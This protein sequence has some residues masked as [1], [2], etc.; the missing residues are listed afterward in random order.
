MR[1]RLFSTRWTLLALALSFAVVSGCG[2]QEAE[3]ELK[4]ASDSVTTAL[5][6]WKRGDSAKSLLTSSPS[7]EFHDDDWQ[8]GARLTDFEI[9]QTYHDTDGAPRS[10]VK[11]T[12]ERDG[13][14]KDTIQVTYQ[15]K[16][17]PKIVV[18]RDPMS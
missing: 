8:S 4:L 14:R 15:A 12:L 16:T 11:L 10:A 7:V 17:E 2:N 3:R 18:A 6:A 9:V 5:D 1:K 13:G